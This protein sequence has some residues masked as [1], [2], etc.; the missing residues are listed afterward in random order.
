MASLMVAS[1]SRTVVSLTPM[2]GPVVG[3]LI[4]T[5]LWGA[6]GTAAGASP[7]GAFVV[8]IQ[9]GYDVLVNAV[10]VAFLVTMAIYL[11]VDDRGGRLWVR[12]ATP[13]RGFD[14]HSCLL[15]LH[16]CRGFLIY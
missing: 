2:Q 9:F 6:L 16:Q 10:A 5:A 7:A 1:S 12:F 8:G 3:W 4:A 13:C 15:V 11:V 14:E